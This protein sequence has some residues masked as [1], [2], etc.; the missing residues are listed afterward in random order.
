[1]CSLNS[2]TVFYSQLNCY[3][4]DIGTKQVLAHNCVSG[5][6]REDLISLSC[7]LQSYNVSMFFMS[8]SSNQEVTI[9]IRAKPANYS[10]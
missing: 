8:D 10:A 9:I 2:Q 6:V 5:K 1:M 7:G 4:G 3:L